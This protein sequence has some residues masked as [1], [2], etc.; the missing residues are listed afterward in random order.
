MSEQAPQA[1]LLAP[2]QLSQQ[3]E[4]DPSALEKI[5][6]FYLTLHSRLQE[7]GA[8]TLDQVVALFMKILQDQLSLQDAL[9]QVRT[10]IPLRR[11]CGYSHFGGQ[12]VP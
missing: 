5:A 10:R 2:E 1:P 11:S 12:K 8:G 3:F 4:L 6:Q 7:H 9:P